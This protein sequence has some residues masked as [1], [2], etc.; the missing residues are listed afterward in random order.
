ML[1]MSTATERTWSSSAPADD[2]LA[3]RPGLS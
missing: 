1:R 2:G 3:R